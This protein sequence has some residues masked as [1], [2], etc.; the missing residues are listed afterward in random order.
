MNTVTR[1]ELE[2]IVAEERPDLESFLNC[3]PINPHIKDA[4]SDRGIPATEV[5][6]TVSTGRSHIGGEDHLY[7]TI[8]PKYVSDVSTTDPIIVDGALDQFCIAKYDAGEVFVT[9][10][11][12]EEIPCPAI[13]ISTDELYDVFFT[14]QNY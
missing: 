5:K 3:N 1:A 4:L 14:E 7:L 8:D 9:L 6:G 12:K 11:P 13:L 2:E 10:G